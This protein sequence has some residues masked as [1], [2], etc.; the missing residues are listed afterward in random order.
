MQVVGCHSADSKR[1][2]ARQW[3]LIES[4][5]FGR[6]IACLDAESLGQNQCGTA[7]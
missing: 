6:I 7:V 5:R 1:E 4:S 2:G 3:R